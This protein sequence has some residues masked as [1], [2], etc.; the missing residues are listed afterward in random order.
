MR[1]RGRG[2]GHDGPDTSDVDDVGDRAEFVELERL[3]LGDHPPVAQRI[4]I[5]PAR[6]A[7]VSQLLVDPVD[8]ILFNFRRLSEGHQPA[9]PITDLDVDVYAVEED[10]L[11]APYRC[12]PAKGNISLREL[13]RDALS[14]SLSGGLDAIGQQAESMY[15]GLPPGFGFGSQRSQLGQLGGYGSMMSSH[16]MNSPQM[17]QVIQHVQQQML[18]QFPRVIPAGQSSGVLYVVDGDVEVRADIQFADEV[19]AL[20]RRLFGESPEPVLE[21]S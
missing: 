10:G 13:M 12:R 19:G 8:S 14:E 21:E 11:R 5:D 15:S 9:G 4:W 1:E 2:A 20:W 3:R 7:A 18:D 6:H 17:S 16:L